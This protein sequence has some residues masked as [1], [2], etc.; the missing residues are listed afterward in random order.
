MPECLRRG[1]GNSKML[2]FIHEIAGV[3]REGAPL[4]RLEP[5]EGKLSRMVLRGVWAG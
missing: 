3:P 2:L 4:G 1:I 5:C